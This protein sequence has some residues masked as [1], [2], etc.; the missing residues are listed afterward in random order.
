MLKL[1]IRMIVLIAMFCVLSGMTIDKVKASVNH[2][3]NIDQSQ[4]ITWFENH[5]G[6]LTYSMY[7]SRNG[8]DGTADC[9]GSMTQAIYDAGGK[10]YQWLYSTDYLHDYL[11]DNHYA[12]IAE[13]KDWIA[14]KGDIVIWGKQGESGGASGHV[15]IISSNDPNANFL[16]TS[17]YTGGQLGTAVQNISYNDFAHLDSFPYTYVYR[18]VKPDESKMKDIGVQTVHF[19]QTFELN[20]YDYWH[21]EW[22]AINNLLSIP[23]TDYN[24]YMPLSGIVLTNKWGQRLT[25]QYAQIGKR[26]REYFQLVGHYKILSNSGD[27]M[28]IEVAGEPVWIKAKYAV[29]D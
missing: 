8:I 19:N 10:Q 16:S 24:N 20:W 11:L 26:Q 7:G 9:S 21:G 13:N 28:A 15:G 4:V 18:Y 6:N 12:L 23:V 3:G 25:N 1:K 27:T 22:Y 5:E 2:D 14:Q 29:K 17:Y